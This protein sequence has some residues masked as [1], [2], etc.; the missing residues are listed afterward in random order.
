MALCS[1]CALSRQFLFA[2]HSPFPHDPRSSAGMIPAGSVSPFC[3]VPPMASLHSRILPGSR[4]AFPPPPPP[5]PPPP[6]IAPPAPPV[7]GHVTSAGTLPSGL[8]MGG[9]GTRQKDRH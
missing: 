3:G 9:P 7:P 2:G 1:E 4:N 5:L 8:Q 6:P